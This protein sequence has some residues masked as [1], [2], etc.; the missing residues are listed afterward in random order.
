MKIVMLQSVFT[1]GFYYIYQ[2]RKDVVLIFNNLL[3]R[4]IGS[5]YPTVD[6]IVQ[7]PEILTALMTGLVGLLA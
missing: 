7:H 5:R 3:R 1:D 6:H 2:G 4:Q